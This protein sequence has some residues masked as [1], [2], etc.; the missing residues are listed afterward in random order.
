MKKLFTL[1]CTIQFSFLLS[2][3][4]PI[5]W[6]RN[7]GGSGFETA[8]SVQQTV[9]NGYI[10]A[11]VNQSTDGDVTGNHGSQDC[12][13]IKTDATGSLQWQKSIGGSGWD[14]AYSIIQTDD[15]GF[16]IAGS[17]DSTDGDITE[18]ID[19]EGNL[20]GWLVKLSS[21]GEIQWEKT[22]NGTSD[23]EFH[24]IRQTGDGGYIAVGYTNLVGYDDGTGDAWIVKTDVTGNIQWQKVFG[25]S[26]KDFF[27]AVDTAQDGGYLLAGSSMSDNG[28]LN[29]NAGDYDAWIVKLDNTGNI[30]WQKSFGGLYFDEARDIHQ[31]E[32]GYIAIITSDQ[33]TDGMFH[34]AGILLKL[35][36]AGNTIW[37]TRIENLNGIDLYS[38]DLTADN[39]YIVAG[40][41]GESG[42]NYYLAKL[43]ATGGLQW[44]TS[45]GGSTVDESRSVKQTQDGGYIVV[46]HSLSSNG[47]VGGNNG[48]NDVWLV[49]LNENLSLDEI[50]KRE[51]YVYPNPVSDILNFSEEVSNIKITELSG[52]MVT[53]ISTKGRSVDVRKLPK[54]VYFITA[55]TKSG[56][57]VTDKIVKE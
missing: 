38:M 15:G 25:G 47:D 21:T 48:S 4:A 16:I 42:D 10:V 50:N 7:F 2:Q 8:S 19:E 35:D 31:T 5:E 56:E 57:T 29:E 20:E 1:L 55:T 12:W 43:N 51:I 6:Q 9:D 41:V 23:N 39:G 22:F 17:T 27:Y 30:L 36:D 34:P 49:K 3:S 44:E 24:S 54:G 40:E 26:D 14:S 52:K 46:G 45:I 33:N 28:D 32:N 18:N 37:E 13:I 53:H 11:G